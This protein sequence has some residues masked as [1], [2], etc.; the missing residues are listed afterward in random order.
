M[1]RRWGLLVF[2]MLAIDSKSEML[3][4]SV[5]TAMAL[6][7][8]QKVEL[9]TLSSV[10]MINEHLVFQYWEMPA[11]ANFSRHDISN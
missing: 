2:V 4:L 5:H 11:Q 7:L 10:A 3:P 8:N 9:E 6:W 1:I